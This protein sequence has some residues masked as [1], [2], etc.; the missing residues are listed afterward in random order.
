MTSIIVLYLGVGVLMT[1]LGLPLWRGLVQPNRWYGLRLSATLG[2]TSTWY[3]A[4]ARFGRI[5]AIIGVAIVVAAGTALAAG[6]TGMGTVIILAVT[7]LVGVAAASIS[8]VLIARSA[9]AR[10]P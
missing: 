3:A 5:L 9:A 6:W 1:F 7:A 4:N 2:S 8:G 10:V